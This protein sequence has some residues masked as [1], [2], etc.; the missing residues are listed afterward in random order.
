MRLF[1]SIQKVVEAGRRLTVSVPASKALIVTNKTKA[2]VVL[3]AEQGAKV[4]YPLEVQE[5]IE[6]EEITETTD[7]FIEIQDETVEGNEGLYLLSQTESE[8]TGRTQNNV[9]INQN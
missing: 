4:G 2:P 7:F 3:F 1:V 9:I 6:I 5:S 8:R